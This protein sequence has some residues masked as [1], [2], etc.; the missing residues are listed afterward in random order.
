[1]WLLVFELRTFGRAVGC[2][3]LLS[4]LSSPRDVLLQDRR[5]VEMNVIRD[6]MRVSINCQFDTRI[7]GVIIYSQLAC[8]NIYVELS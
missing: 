3:Y 6:A 2:S 1:M 5:T 8:G 4:H 7:N